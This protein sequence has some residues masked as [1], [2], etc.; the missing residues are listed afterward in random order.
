MKKNWTKEAIFQS[1][2]FNSILLIILMAI[3]IFYLYPQYNLSEEKI[4]TFSDVSNNYQTLV[5]KGLSFTEFNIIHKKDWKSLKW[6]D[7][8]LLNNILTDFREDDYNTHFS[9][10]G[11]IYEKFLDWKVIDAKEKRE[12]QI[13]TNISTKINEILPEYSSD[14]SLVTDSLTDFKF[15]NHIEWL[16]DTFQL[17]SKDKI[18]IWQ[19]T[20]TWKESVKKW[21]KS[22]K[23]NPLNGVIYEWKLKLD[24]IWEKKNIVNFIHYIENVWK[25]TVDNKEV[26]IYEETNSKFYID[27]NDERVKNNFLDISDY[28]KDWINPYDGLIMEV[29]DLSFMEYMD[30]SDLPT[31]DWYNLV[32]LIKEWQ[33]NEKFQINITL[34]YYV[35]GLPTFKIEKFIEDVQARY[36]NLVKISSSWFEYVS[37]NRASL[38]D[39][40]AISAIWS[41]GNI[42]KYLLGLKIDIKNLG[43]ELKKGEDL[44]T[45]YKTAQELD[46]IFEVITEK[47]S[48]D[49]Q[50]VSETL[51]TKHEAI[52]NNNS[53]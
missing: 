45:V 46:S 50:A 24:L 7:S 32:Q 31:P 43:I 27:N 18:W 9:H 14:S 44:G 21:E 49:L 4:N 39:S 36:W 11:A 35:K 12:A 10:T 29:D 53:K 47:L 13:G 15:I 23:K 30:S 34:K 40:N 3:A 51:Y 25:I 26:N 52:L 22:V 5:E 20:E 2:I 41:L 38:N 19:L 37:K 6:W 17:S 8:A 16:L 33:A 48:V 1:F 28:F 42:N